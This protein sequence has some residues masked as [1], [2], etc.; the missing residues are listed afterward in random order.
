MWEQAADLDD[1]QT[2][3]YTTIEGGNVPPEEVELARR[4]LDERSFRQVSFWPA[5][6]PSRVECF[7]SFGQDNIRDD[8]KDMGG[9]ILG[10]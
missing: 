2:F 5:S 6:R 10:M 1:W 9:P 7:R 8:I 3:S 4:T